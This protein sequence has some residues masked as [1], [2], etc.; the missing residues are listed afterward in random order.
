MVS[1]L[2]NCLVDKLNFHKSLNVVDVQVQPPNTYI[3][4]LST[5]VECEYLF[6]MVFAKS[7]G[8]IE[9]QIISK[10]TIAR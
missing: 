2:S 3:E 8:L 1:N 6:A 7:I 5:T 10:S 4:F 9:S